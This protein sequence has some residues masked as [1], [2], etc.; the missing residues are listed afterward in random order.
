M[1]RSRFLLVMLLCVALVA[2]RATGMHLHLCFDGAEPAASLHLTDDGTAG[3]THLVGTG[4]AH[5]DLDLSLI[6]EVLGKLSKSSFN[7]PVVLL[8]CALLFLFPR[9]ATPI[10]RPVLWGGFASFPRFI[11]PPLRGPPR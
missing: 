6:D 7:L 10:P 4:P 11:R 2:V 3:A 9:A 5:D 8:T 1:I